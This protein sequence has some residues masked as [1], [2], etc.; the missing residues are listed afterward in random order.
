MTTTSASRSAMHWV[1]L[2]GT[3]LSMAAC[4]LNLLGAYRGPQ[5]SQE[6]ITNEV[7]IV[8]SEY[9]SQLGQRQFIMDRVRFTEAGDPFNV[10]RVVRVST[11]E[12]TV[13]EVI[14]FGLQPG[15]RVTISTVYI[16]NR[17]VGALTEVPNWPGHR[18]HE[19]PIGSHLFTSVALTPDG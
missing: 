9:D 8:R 19:Y 2:C 16:G 15:D 1:L 17:R 7:V 13:A 3:A 4:D 6:D 5:P 12:A 10:D 11:T 14:E 18:Y